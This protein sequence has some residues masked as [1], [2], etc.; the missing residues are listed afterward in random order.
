MPS[1]KDNEGR[2]WS[3]SIDL[4]SVGEVHRDT[5]VSI[6]TLM[7][8]EMKGL[9]ELC[10]NANKHVL[11]NVVYLLCK[12]KADER[13]LTARDF[14]KALKGDP[15]E[16]MEFAFCEALADFFPDAR[17][18]DAIHKMIAAGKRMR[19]KLLERLPAATKEIE[20]LNTDQLIDSFIAT[21]RSTASAGKPSALSGSA[22]EA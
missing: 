20:D 1:F 19:D 13:N 18:R 15:I 11:A 17:R 3:V 5:G 12:E 10:D 4:F 14:A 16:A 6:Y 9:A 22:P 7:D 2:E 8:D 21:T